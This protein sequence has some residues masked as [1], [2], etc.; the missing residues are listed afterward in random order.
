[1]INGVNLNQDGVEIKK[2]VCYFCHNN[3]GL[4]AYVKDGQVLKVEGDDSYPVNQGA[5]CSRG[6]IN[7]LFLNHPNRLNHPLKRVGAR[8]AGDPGKGPCNKPG[9]P[10]NRGGAG[11]AGQAWQ[12]GGRS[13]VATRVMAVVAWYRD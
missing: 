10:G 4:L 5:L 1:M 11:A 6:N 7:H 2:S 8:G 3:C 13:A 9:L 12:L